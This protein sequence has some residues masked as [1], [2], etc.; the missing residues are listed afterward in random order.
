MRCFLLSAT[1]L[2][3]LLTGRAAAQVAPPPPRPEAPALAAP[4]AP[5]DTVA[6]LHRLFA[7]RRQ[8]R[9]ILVGV[10]GALTVGLA[11]GA[12]A[13]TS[14][15]EF[16]SPAGAAILVGIL[17]GVVVASELAFFGKYSRKKEQRAVERFQA[18]RL[19][20][21]LR[22]KLKPRYFH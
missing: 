4:A 14:G 15:Q 16:I 3:A 11:I 12:G 1:L 17:G 2:L 21:D 18:H 10:T 8:R 19:D 22:R 20:R 7:E 13:S 9:N 5:T 6:A